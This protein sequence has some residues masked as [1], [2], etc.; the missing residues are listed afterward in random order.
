MSAVG[1]EAD[2]I[3]S[4]ADINLK[5]MN[6]RP[7]GVHIDRRCFSAVGVGELWRV[8]SIAAVHLFRHGLPAM[9][10]FPRYQ[11]FRDP[12]S[13]RSG[14]PCNPNDPETG[15]FRRKTPQFGVSLSPAMVTDSIGTV[16]AV[17]AG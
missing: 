16:G 17:C 12:R 10:N 9:P 11:A 7:F 14:K 8:C 6:R 4:K 3:R 13:D 5:S 15:L 1:G 2:V